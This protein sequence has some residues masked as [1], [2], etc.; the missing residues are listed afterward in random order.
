MSFTDI[1]SPESFA[2]FLQSQLSLCD[3][4]IDYVSIISSPAFSQ[5]SVDP[6]CAALSKAFSIFAFGTRAQFL[7]EQIPV[8]L[9]ESQDHFLRRLS[10]ARGCLGKSIVKFSDLISF[11]G[12]LS[13]DEIERSVIDALEHNLINCHIDQ[14][15]ESLYVYDVTPG[16]PDPHLLPTISEGIASLLN[17]C[18]SLITE[19][20]NS[21]TLAEELI[22][23]EGSNMISGFEE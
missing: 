13:L 5:F 4:N 6:D 1:S 11:L 8:P 10:V 23:C 12:P 2:I 14:E 15:K 22:K 21:Q 20:E 16:A 3:P 19:M 9:T 18:N 7:N 17:R